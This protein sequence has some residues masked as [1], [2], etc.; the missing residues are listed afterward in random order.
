MLLVYLPRHHTRDRSL[1][2]KPT[3]L[4]VTCVQVTVTVTVHHSG[5]KCIGWTERPENSGILVSKELRSIEALTH[6]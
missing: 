2:Q 5:G 3:V 6:I 4:P 1:K